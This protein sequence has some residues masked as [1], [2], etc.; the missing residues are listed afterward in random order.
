MTENA[1]TLRR[2]IVFQKRMAEACWINRIGQF[3]AHCRRRRVD[4]VAGQQPRATAEQRGRIKVLHQ[5]LLF[6]F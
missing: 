6:K 5:P 4:A 1:K 3:G 2:R